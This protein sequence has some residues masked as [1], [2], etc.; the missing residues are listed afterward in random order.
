M[1][2][3]ELRSEKN[4]VILGDK[5]FTKYFLADKNPYNFYWWAKDNGFDMGVY[6]NHPKVLNKTLCDSFGSKIP[7]RFSAA[8]YNTFIRDNFPRE[9]HFAISHLGYH[10]KR[11][12]SVRVNK[13]IENYHLVEQALRDKTINLLPLMLAYGEDTQQLKRRFGKGLWKKL[14]NTSKSRMKYLAE[15]IDADGEWV[16][17]RTGILEKVKGRLWDDSQ[18][19]AARL[20]PTVRQYDETYHTIADTIRM[21]K[22][23]Y[24]QYNTDWS[25]KRWQEEHDRLTNMVLLGRYSDKPFCDTVTYEED[26]YTFILL[27]NQMA[28]ATEG[29]VMHHCVGSYAG[30]AAEGSYAVF[31]VEGKERATLGLNLVTQGDERFEFD[32]CYGLC[33]SR[34]SD[35]LRDAAYKILR[36]FNDDRIRRR[37][38]RVSGG[39]DQGSRSLVDN[40]WQAVPLD[41]QLQRNAFPAV[42]F[43]DLD[44]PQHLPF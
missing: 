29:K 28:I 9:T 35:K 43:Y 44:R 2:K 15:V 6:D 14:A 25:L 37:D 30:R 21:A 40:G 5:E 17:V 34:V 18:L 27:N 1:A 26:G 31:K 22:Q 19:I 13:A 12:N 8:V 32:Q 16:D 11:F 10:W 38:G 7:Y 41:Q 4:K 36:K 23:R 42:R 20:S 24:E 33:N 3:Y 39:S